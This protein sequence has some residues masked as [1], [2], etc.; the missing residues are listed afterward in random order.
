MG[1]GT[2][3]TTD[4]TGHENFQAACSGALS[5]RDAILA[6]HALIVDTPDTDEGGRQAKKL[7]STIK[8]LE[9]LQTNV[10]DSSH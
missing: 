3:D 5:K 1:E 2:F 4:K 7:E 10:V 6:I 8:A 9:V